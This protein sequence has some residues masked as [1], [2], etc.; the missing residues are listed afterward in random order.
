MPLN[1]RDYDSRCFFFFYTYIS[2][3]YEQTVGPNPNP[4]VRRSSLKIIVSY[5]TLCFQQ[6]R[7]SMHFRGMPKV[8]TRTRCIRQGGYSVFFYL[9]AKDKGLDH[10][11][12]I[13]K[14]RRRLRL[15]IFH[16]ENGHVA[17]RSS[18]GS[19]LYTAHVTMAETV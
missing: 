7:H 17:A 18:N 2:Y 13:V 10:W 14:Q 5:F 8:A 12:S 16:H 9:S 3:Y 1:R 6:R 4:A 11:E 19:K 15:T